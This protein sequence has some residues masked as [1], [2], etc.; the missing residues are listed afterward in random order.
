MPNI[1]AYFVLFS[2]PVVVIVLFNTLDRSKAIVASI[3]AGYLLLPSLPVID[4]PAAPPLDKALIPVLSAAVMCLL[5]RPKAGSAVVYQ[6]SAIAPGGKTSTSS[7]AVLILLLMVLFA[8]GF[9]TVLTN[10]EA[11]QFGPTFLP[12]MRVYDGFSIGL[13]TLVY[14]LPFLLGAKYLATEGDHKKLLGVMAMAGVAYSLLALFEVRMSPQL[15]LWIY[16]YFPHSFAQHVRAGGFRP[17]VFLEHGLWVSI[18][19]A[20]ATLSGAVLLRSGSVAAAN[21]LRWMLFLAWMLITLVLVK[22]LGA[23][24]ITLLLLPV[25]LFGTRAW[26]LRA[27]SIVAII[28]LAYPMLRG[29]DWVPVDKVSELAGQINPERAHSFNV[30]ISNED[31][32]LERAQEKPY[33]G[34]GGWGRN[35]IFDPETGRNISITDGMWVIFVGTFGWLGYIA[36]FGMLTF[37]LLTL[38]K[39]RK[40][41]PIPIAT[42]GLAVVV[43]ANLIDLIP[44]ATLTPVTWLLAGALA[45]YV[46][47][48]SEPV[49]VDEKAALADPDQAVQLGGQRPLHVRKPR[50]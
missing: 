38:V 43:S 14:I 24:M 34:W 47:R 19:L 30:R 23:L 22:S 8:S 7:K 48:A 12:P 5:M 33:F 45:G 18:F 27:A 6:R 4:L 17:I 37:P 44:N 26:M 31:A 2:W 28:V 42:A 3:V 9:V 10:G 21:S 35:E 15:N 39:R 36:R 1:V 32:L 11:L 50:A 25:I 20:T 29:L 16:G 46:L 13:E 41:Q 49:V 40:K